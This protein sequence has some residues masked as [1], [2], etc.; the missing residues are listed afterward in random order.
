MYTISAASSGIIVN[1]AR[2][3]V[4][5]FGSVGS[6]PSGCSPVFE[7]REDDRGDVLRK[8]LLR[9]DVYDG[10]S[11]PKEETLAATLLKSLVR[12]EIL[13]AKTKGMSP[14]CFRPGGYLIHQRVPNRTRL[15]IR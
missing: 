9:P 15:W 12:D 1:F 6:E 13:P 7:S 11:K 5:D 8:D 14:G 4:S 3:L 2:A 10:V